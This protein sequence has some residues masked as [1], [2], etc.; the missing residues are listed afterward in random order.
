MYFTRYNRIL[1]L[2]NNFK[3]CDYTKKSVMKFCGHL[4]EQYNALTFKFE[5]TRIVFICF[6]PTANCG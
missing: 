2:I 4:S 1:K 6:S 5:I 3:I